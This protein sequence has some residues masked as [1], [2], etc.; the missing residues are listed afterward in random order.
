LKASDIS[1]ISYIRI[2]DFDLLGM[3]VQM[4]VMQKYTTEKNVTAVVMNLNANNENKY[5]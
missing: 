3:Y 4:Y 2:H 1:E 5:N